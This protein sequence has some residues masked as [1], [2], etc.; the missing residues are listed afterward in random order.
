MQTDIDF[1]ITLACKRLEQLSIHAYIAEKHKETYSPLVTKATQVFWCT[2]LLRLLWGD[3]TERLLGEDEHKEIRAVIEAR[4]GG[5][6]PFEWEG[7]FSHIVET[8]PIKEPVMAELLRSANVLLALHTSFLV[9]DRI[10]IVPLASALKQM[11]AVFVS[12]DKLVLRPEIQKIAL[13]TMYHYDSRWLK[14]KHD[15]VF[16]RTH[17]LRHQGVSEPTIAACSPEILQHFEVIVYQQLK[18]FCAID[19]IIGSGYSFKGDNLIIET[20]A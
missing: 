15:I 2:E 7:A 9:N 6:F 8:N 10:T 3:T 4:Y 20:I 13:L 14:Q 18:H 19:E 16:D 12:E 17:W 1:Y 5:F 11:N